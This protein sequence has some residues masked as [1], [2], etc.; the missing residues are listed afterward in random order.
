MPNVFRISF[1]LMT[2]FGRGNII[3][4]TVVAFEATCTIWNYKVSE[5]RRIWRV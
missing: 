1:T 2:T 3:I 4:A 5:V